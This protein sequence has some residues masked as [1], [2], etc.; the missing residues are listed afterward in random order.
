MCCSRNTSF[1]YLVSDY[2][3]VYRVGTNYGRECCTILYVRILSRVFLWAS[4]LKLLK[5]S[6]RSQLSV[7]SNDKEIVDIPQ[8][9]KWSVKCTERRGKLAFFPK[10][11]QNCLLWRSISTCTRFGLIPVTDLEIFCT[12]FRNSIWL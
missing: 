3:W 9:T 7:Q 8:D 2:V 1:I 11:S 6:T 12:F 5:A 4:L 10:W